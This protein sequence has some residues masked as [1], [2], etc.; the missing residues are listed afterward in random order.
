[1]WW[2]EKLLI[3]VD[4]NLYAVYVAPSKENDSVIGQ[5]VSLFIVR[6]L[7]PATIVAMMKLLQTDIV[8]I[9]SKEGIILKKRMFWKEI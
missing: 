8:K 6:F 4:S 2:H 9:D 7:H 1:M 5:E 3:V